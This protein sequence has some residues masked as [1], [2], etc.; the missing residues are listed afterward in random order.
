MMGRG[1]HGWRFAVN[2]NNFTEKKYSEVQMIMGY[3]YRF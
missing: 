1:N 2:W 3:M